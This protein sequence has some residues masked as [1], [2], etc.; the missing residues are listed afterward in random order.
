[1]LRWLLVVVMLPSGNA[2]A[3]DGLTPDQQHMRAC[4]TQ[5]KEKQLSGA[6][7]SRFM[8]HCLNGRNGKPP[9][10]TP[11]QA[12]NEACTKEADERRLEGAARRGFMSDCV[13][14][15]RVKQQ[16]AEGKK[17][18]DCNRRAGS[19]RLD[20]EQRKKFVAGCLDGSTTING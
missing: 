2:L 6:E 4:N 1:M 9:S 10:P 13:K 16:T 18:K 12:K 20:D 15:D 7:R 5:A 17:L 14:P 3:D 19:R 11:R 8:S